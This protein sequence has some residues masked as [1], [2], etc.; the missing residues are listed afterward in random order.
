MVVN[1]VKIVIAIISQKMVFDVLT[2]LAVVQ[3]RHI[4]YH[5]YV[6]SENYKKTSKLI[7]I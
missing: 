6:V 2:T 4:M 3:M 7:T 5:T 1:A